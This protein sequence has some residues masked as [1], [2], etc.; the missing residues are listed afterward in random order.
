MHDICQLVDGSAQEERD[1]VLREDKSGEEFPN[2]WADPN[3]QNWMW[4]FDAR[5]TAEVA[6]QEFIHRKCNKRMLEQDEKYI[7]GSKKTW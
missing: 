3:F 1:R 7:V 6:W 5:L 2:P 4:A